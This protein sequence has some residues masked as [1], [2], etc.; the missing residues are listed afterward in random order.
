MATALNSSGLLK[1]GKEFL[2]CSLCLDYYTNAKT[3]PCLHSYCEKCLL[4][5]V[6]KRGELVC[7]ECRAVV[8]LT[9]SAED[10]VADVGA[11]CFINGVVEFFKTLGSDEYQA[12]VPDAPC[13]ACEDNSTKIPRE[14]PNM[15]PVNKKHTVT[16]NTVDR[17]RNRVVP[18][19]GEEVSARLDN[20]DYTSTALTVVSDGN[21]SHTLTIPGQKDGKYKLNIYVGD[22]HIAGSPFN[23][24]VVSDGSRSEAQ[25]QLT[26]PNFSNMTSEVYSTPVIA[27]NISW[28]ISATKEDIEESDAKGLAIYLNADDCSEFKPSYEASNWNYSHRI[29]K[30]EFVP[31]KVT[32]QLQLLNWKQHRFPRDMELIHLFETPSGYGYPN[33]IDLEVSQ[34]ILL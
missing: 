16:I 17:D 3:L 20:P 19:N 15:I 1:I 24:Q 2:T 14:I 29:N 8:P 5:L 33:F 11:N 25:L 34:F 4:T 7:P 21:G 10:T 22:S 6:E 31:S 12:G 23:I 18:F 30:T 9:G 32:A 27:K 28:K 26:I 13:D